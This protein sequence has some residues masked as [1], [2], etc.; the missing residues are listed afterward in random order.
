M[1]HFVRTETATGLAMV[2][3]DRAADDGQARPP[4]QRP[5]V[6]AS[7]AVERRR[8][9]RRDEL[10]HPARGQARRLRGLARTAG[11]AMPSRAAKARAKARRQHSWTSGNFRV[12]EFRLPLVDARLAGPKAVQV[13]PSS[14]AVDV[15]MS[16]FSGGPMSGAALRASAL[17][18]SRSPS[19]AGYDEFSF[20]P[21]RDPKKAEQEGSENE[22]GDAAA[23][24]GKLVAD[25][26]PLDDRPQRRRELHAQ[27]P[28][29]GRAAE[30]DRRRGHA[31]PT[32]TARPRPSAT[33]DRPLA[34]RG[35]ARRARGF[36]G[37]QPRQRKVH[38]ARA[39]HRAASRSR[40]RASRSRAASARSSRPASAWSAASTPTTTAPR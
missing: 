2:P 36:L 34:E 14:V 17:L 7:A 1:K 4:G 3:A 13:A 38:R 19:F 27:G 28:A 26:L 24:D 8:A 12:E 15:Q 6:R 22:E 31:S 30:P 32:R 37:E 11:R 10:E 23:R 21:P 29:E 35:R 33:P 18:K 20:E 39:R 25:K 40:A 16:Y 5:G 9:Q